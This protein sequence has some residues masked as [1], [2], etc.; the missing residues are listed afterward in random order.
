MAQ[1][2][3]KRFI[4]A[5]S[6]CLLCFSVPTYAD[7]QETE[8]IILLNQERK[9]KGRNP[10]K[11]SEVLT[12]VAEN[13]ARDMVAGNYFSHTGKDGSS[14]GNRIKR[15]GYKYC[16]AAENIALGQKTAKA[17]M[18]AWQNS[19]GHKKNNLSKKATEVG[20]GYAGGKMWVLV[21]AKP[22]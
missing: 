17:V 14:V 12:N 15:Q 22:C 5:L 8:L 7:T 10:L 21:F 3:A 9:A 1:M 18:V 13:H 20:A 6:T 19:S 2:F 16:Y 4:Y 11:V